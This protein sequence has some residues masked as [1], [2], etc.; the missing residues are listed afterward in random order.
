MENLVLVLTANGK[1]HNLYIDDIS[2]VT[3]KAQTEGL[4]SPSVNKPETLT[5]NQS[6]KFYV[7]NGIPA[8]QL[9]QLTNS[10]K[11]F[12]ID[13][14]N[15]VKT[16]K[17]TWVKGGA[18]RGTALDSETAMNEKGFTGVDLD[19]YENFLKSQVEII[20]KHKEGKSALT[21]WQC[22]IL[23]VKNAE[24]FLNDNMTIGNTSFAI[25]N[26]NKP[27][28]KPVEQPKSTTA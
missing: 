16:D 11:N 15:I 3:F 6:V 19:K 24:K 14:G 26:R 18:G 7:A 2:Q 17:L 20:T 9:K 13:K 21:Q 4:I 28:E 22:A 10:L 23:L 12:G 5:A 8:A 27:E 1:E 25:P